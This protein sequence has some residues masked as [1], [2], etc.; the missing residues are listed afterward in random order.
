MVFHQQYFGTQNQL[1]QLLIFEWLGFKEARTGAYPL[2]NGWV[3]HEKNFE[4][5][6]LA[7]GSAFQAARQWGP[8]KY[9][10]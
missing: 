1:V 9:V 10:H 6:N 7:P 8:T 2:K 4:T 5:L 3:K